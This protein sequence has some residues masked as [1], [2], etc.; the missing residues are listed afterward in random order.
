MAERMKENPHDFFSSAEKRALVL[1][2]LDKYIR[3]L[4][5]VANKAKAYKIPK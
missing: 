1:Q 2:G 3:N 4:D 5:T